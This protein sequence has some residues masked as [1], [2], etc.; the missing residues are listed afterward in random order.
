MVMKKGQKS[1]FA[2]GIAG[3]VKATVKVNEPKLKK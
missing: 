3:V 1:A 2:N